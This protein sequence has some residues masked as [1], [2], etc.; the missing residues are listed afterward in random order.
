MVPIS[1]TFMFAKNIF[2]YI[3]YFIDDGKIR[4]DLNDEIIA[5]SI[6]TKRWQTPAQKQCIRSNG[7]CLKE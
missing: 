6:V 7:P 2:N 5:S 1:S 4:L 3:S